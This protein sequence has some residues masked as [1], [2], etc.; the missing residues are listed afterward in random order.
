MDHII[1]T[2][3][4]VD[5]FEVVLCGTPCI[6]TSS[7]IPRSVGQFNETSFLVSFPTPLLFGSGYAAEEPIN[8]SPQKKVPRSWTRGGT[9][10]SRRGARGKPPAK[11]NEIIIGFRTQEVE[12]CQAFAACL[13]SLRVIKLGR[14]LEDG[15][16]H[17]G[18]RKVWV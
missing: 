5:S 10:S 12:K 7:S 8:L 6:Q 1:K 3:L 11:D 17:L 16:R 15:P 13:V 4:G 18:T 14:S 9:V 2:L